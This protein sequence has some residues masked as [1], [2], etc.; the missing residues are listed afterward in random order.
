MSHHSEI[1][2]HQWRDPNSP[3]GHL[4]P[5][6]IRLVVSHLYD[7]NLNRSGAV[8]QGLAVC[9]LV[10][11]YWASIIRPLLFEN[12]E[13]RS[14][15][16]AIQLLKFLESPTILKPALTECVRLLA[17]KQ[18][19][20]QLPPWM[21]LCQLAKYYRRGDV[22]LLIEDAEGDILWYGLPRALP[23]SIFLHTNKLELDRVRFRRGRDLVRFIRSLPE[24]WSCICK[25]ITFTDTSP[26]SPVPIPR[27]RSLESLAKLEFDLTDCSECPF[28]TQLTLA[29]AVLAARERLRVAV[30][31]WAAAVGAILA[32]VPS[33]WTLRRIG[34]DTDGTLGLQSVGH[35]STDRSS[36]R[37]ITCAGFPRSPLNWL[38]CFASMSQSCGTHTRRS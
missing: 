32:L 30:D 14:R 7:V 33:S 6:L 8:K 1:R 16:D 28:A 12:I 22:R 24:V 10:C 11:R 17:F 3:A 34:V 13:L 37:Q 29:F 36:V 18:S 4:A 38:S 21:H 26:V 31:S 15:E 2:Q 35:A 5:E 25:A 23:Q 27:R 20:R 19:G 9:G